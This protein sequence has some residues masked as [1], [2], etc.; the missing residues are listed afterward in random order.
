VIGV[1][2]VEM[3]ILAAKIRTDFRLSV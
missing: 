1:P 2:A 3:V